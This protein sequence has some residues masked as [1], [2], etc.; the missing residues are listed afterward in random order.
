MDKALVNTIRT[1]RRRPRPGLLPVPD[2]QINALLEIGLSASNG[3]GAR[4]WHFVV[5]REEPLRRRVS[6]ALRNYPSLEDASVMVAATVRSAARGSVSTDL[7]L[8]AFA[9]GMLV[10][11]QTMEL[12]AVWVGEPT[13]LL[14]PVVE[15]MLLQELQIPVQLGVRIPG[16]MALGRRDADRQRKGAQNR[17]RPGALTLLDRGTVATLVPREGW[18]G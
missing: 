5:I 1:R 10:G 9:E 3:Q 18:E 11:A 14:W 7:G 2:D 13:T 16:L 4:P 17:S 12:G 15:D 8:G 6:D